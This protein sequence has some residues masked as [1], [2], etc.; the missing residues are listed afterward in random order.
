MSLRMPTYIP[1]RVFG[2]RIDELA[3]A[4]ASDLVVDQL[5]HPRGASK[6]VRVGI[7]VG[8]DVSAGVADQDRL[9]ALP[10]G[11]RPRLS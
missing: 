4:E 6:P 7:R 11:S 1:V 5:E 10:C 3:L 2:E 9:V 8:V